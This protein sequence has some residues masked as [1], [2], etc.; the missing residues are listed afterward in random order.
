MK[1]SKLTTKTVLIA[2][3]IVVATASI[4]Y[5]TLKKDEVSSW[6]ESNW[7]YR[8][9]IYLQTEENLGNITDDVLIEVDTQS[10][11]NQNKLSLECEDLRFVDSDNINTLPYWIEGGCNTPYTQVWVRI[12]ADTRISDKIIYMY[13][14]NDKAVDNQET[15]DGYFISLREDRNTQCCEIT[16]EFKNRFVRG[17]EEY[18]EVSGELTHEHSYL[19]SNNSLGCDNPVTVA[20]LENDAQCNTDQD[21]VISS[22]TTL[23][24]NIPEYKELLFYKVTDGYLDKGNIIIYDEKPPYPWNTYTPLVNKFPTGE[25]SDQ[26]SNTSHTHSQRCLNRNL[27]QPDGDQRY[28]TLKNITTITAQ[29]NEP[30]FKTVNYITN[31]EQTTLPINSIMMTTQIPPLGWQIYEELNGYFAKGSDSNFLT[32]GGNN[33]HIHTSN[34]NIEIKSS[35]TEVLNSIE[36]TQICIDMNSIKD[37]TQTSSF[38]PYITTIFAQKKESVYTVSSSKLGEEENIEGVLG[39]STTQPSAPTGLETEGET[40]PTDLE[41]LT[42]GFTAIFNHPDYP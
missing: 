24:S 17:S 40:N 36:T 29:S 8:K 15:W 9:A 14:G 39:T 7:T 28:L 6:Y 5:L 35:T 11:I 18:G 2:S 20:I 3:S 13:Y 22:I 23:G 33:S 34:L 41:T 10:L 4:L 38:P 19:E 25:G 27:Y 16:N 42:P 21:N 1:N 12:T 26:F 30:E 32:T 37:S 31:T